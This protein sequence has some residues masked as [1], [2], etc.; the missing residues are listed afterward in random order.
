MHGVGQCRADD[1]DRRRRLPRRDR[2]TDGGGQ[3]DIRL[4][5]DDLLRKCR[6]PVQKALSIAVRHVELAAFNV[7]ELPHTVQKARD[8]W[9]GYFGCSSRQ[10]GDE[11]PPLGGA[12]RPCRDRPRDGRAAECAKEFPSADADCHRALIW[13]AVPDNGATISQRGCACSSSRWPARGDGNSS[14]I[15]FRSLHSRPHHAKWIFAGSEPAIV[16]E[17]VVHW[18]FTPLHT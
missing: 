10:P 17:V 18:S 11:P 6:Q 8:E 1:R 4:E 16:G 14:E 7:T 3:D 12:L 15:R 13:I 9:F 2:G 5:P